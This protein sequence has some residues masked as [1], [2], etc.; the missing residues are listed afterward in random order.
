MKIWFELSWDPCF[1]KTLPWTLQKLNS[2]LS[3]DCKLYTPVNDKN[4]KRQKN[5][6]D[7]FIKK[8]HL[9]DYCMKFM[10]KPENRD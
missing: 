2:F 8:I 7:L 6:F 4:K 3:I 5:L 9:N 10:K 1:I